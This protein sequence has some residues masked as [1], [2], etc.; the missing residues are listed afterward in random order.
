M[1]KI[2]KINLHEKCRKIL[3]EKIEDG[4]TKSSFT[5][6]NFLSLDILSNLNEIENSLPESTRQQLKAVISE[7]PVR[8]FIYSEIYYDLKNNRTRDDNCKEQSLRS[9]DKYKD[10]GTVSDELINNLLNP[11]RSYTI[12]FEILGSYTDCSLWS[13]LEKNSL[14]LS[15]SV[16]LVQ[17]TS[18]D[19]EKKYLI[20]Q[21]KRLGLLESPPLSSDKTCLK[22][23]HNGYFPIFDG[24]SKKEVYNIFKES[25]LI[26]NTTGLVDIR[27]TP[28]QRD[29][30][31]FAFENISEDQYNHIDSFCYS[32]GYGFYPSINVSD[33]FRNMDNDRKPEFLANASNQIQTYF[34]M[35]NKVRATA[36]W[37]MNSYLS[38]NNLLAYIQA[39][40]AIEILLGEKKYT[41]TLGIQNLISNRMAYSIAKS[42][43]ERNEIISK[44]K[45]IYD[46][47]S[48]I[49]HNGAEEL[50]DTAQDDLKQ[51]QNYIHRLLRHEIDLASY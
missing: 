23:S 4:I 17:L 2:I 14:K 38:E 51:L 21:E 11:I 49:V 20:T 24:P 46:T 36:R 39:T 5:S 29:K 41:D 27:S 42:P 30:S 8:D 37:L 18:L 43:A 10:I 33:Y 35:N 44:F 45:E 32:S 28:I 22:I 40:T 47:R 13:F 15:D 26:C 50:G 19:L 12:F 6:N 1:N 3:K 7:N 16:E 25:L 31:Y 34:N 9:I 48:N